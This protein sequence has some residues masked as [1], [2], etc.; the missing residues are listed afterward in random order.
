VSEIYVGTV[1]FVSERGFLFLIPDGGAGPD[2]FGHISEW[3][4]NGL[5]EPEAGE[6]Y[7]FEIVQRPKGPTAVNPKPVM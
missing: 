3:E 1:K 2:V 7:E 4:R 6:K 5:R